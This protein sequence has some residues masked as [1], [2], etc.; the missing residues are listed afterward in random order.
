MQNSSLNLNEAIFIK[1]MMHLLSKRIAIHNLW[2]KGRNI[3][4]EVLDALIANIEDEINVVRH[5]AS[6]VRHEFEKRHQKQAVAR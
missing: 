4:S 3:G 2:V 1:S 6:K 5:N